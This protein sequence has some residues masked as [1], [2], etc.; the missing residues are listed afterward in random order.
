MTDSSRVH[1]TLAAGLFAAAVFLEGW[2]SVKVSR[3]GVCCRVA[4]RGA[5]RSAVVVPNEEVITSRNV[6]KRV[7]LGEC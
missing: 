7:L 6:K 1:F 4:R 5:V 2:G 3:G